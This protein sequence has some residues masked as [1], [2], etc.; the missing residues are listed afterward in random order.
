MLASGNLRS[1][2]KHNLYTFKKLLFHW[3]MPNILSSTIPGPAKFYLPGLGLVWFEE[4][5]VGVR[6]QKAT[7]WDKIFLHLYYISSSQSRARTKSPVSQSTF[8]MPKKEKGTQNN[9]DKC[10]SLLST[11]HDASTEILLFS[12][13]INR[14]KSNQK[15]ILWYP[16]HKLC[17]I[18]SLLES[19]FLICS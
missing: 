5:G 13:Y 17:S 11:Y 9:K 12:F 8:F 18:L 7:H 6:S 2:K 1:T 4:A 3:S 10:Y 16:N 14:L 19:L 15:T